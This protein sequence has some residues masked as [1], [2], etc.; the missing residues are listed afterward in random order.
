M[1]IISYRKQCRNC[2]FDSG[3]KHQIDY[4]ENAEF[5]FNINQTTFFSANE[6]VLSFLKTSNSKCDNCKSTNMWILSDFQI[7]STPIDFEKKGVRF[8]IES[9][10]IQ[11]FFVDIFSIINNSIHKIDL[12][13]GSNKN[14]ETAWLINLYHTHIILQSYY[15]INLIPSKEIKSQFINMIEQA[16]QLNISTKYDTYFRT[17]LKWESEIVNTNFL[18]NYIKEF[19]NY[20]EFLNKIYPK[21][22][23]NESS[24]NT[25][26]YF[27][28][29]YLLTRQF[30]FH[31]IDKL[32]PEY[33][34]MDN[35]QQNRQNGITNLIQKL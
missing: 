10:I 8:E 25:Y 22:K 1:N 21:L 15:E 16:S 20:K 19:S 3:L 31:F 5:P 35:D 26:N 12:K 33:L 27:L 14:S 2:G 30:L 28:K 34:S 13:L 29:Q 17:I 23:L 6:E 18:G 4:E 7:N 11:Y 9:G 24:K 32:F